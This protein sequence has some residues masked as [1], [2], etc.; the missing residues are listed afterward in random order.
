LPSK[1]KTSFPTSPRYALL[2]GCHNV[3]N[4]VGQYNGAFTLNMLGIKPTGAKNEDAQFDN[5]WIA[6]GMRF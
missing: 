6:V 2:G 4:A 5:M 1:V 3:G